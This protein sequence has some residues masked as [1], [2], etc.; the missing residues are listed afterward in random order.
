MSDVNGATL[1]TS[2]LK[3]EPSNLQFSEQ[4]QD[5]R[6]MNGRDNT[7]SINMSHET[8][9]LY[10][11]A[12]SANPVELAF[13]AKYGEIISYFWFGGQCSPHLCATQLPSHFKIFGVFFRRGIQMDI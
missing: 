13:Q 6:S 2:E 8:L 11:M 5:D 7:I 4:K 3:H 12:D 9:L 10:N 1:I